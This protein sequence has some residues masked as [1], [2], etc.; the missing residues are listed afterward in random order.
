MWIA[1][2]LRL[3][4]N[5]DDARQF[6]STTEAD[7]SALWCS[8]TSILRVGGRA[9]LKPMKMNRKNKGKRNKAKTDNK[10]RS[11][12]KKIA[13]KKH[14]VKVT[15]ESEARIIIL[16]GTSMNAGEDS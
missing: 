4:A 14:S 6:P 9:G 11:N 15:K 3:K 13:K 2:S 16:R 10:M 8:Y 5:L 1:S 12:K 7:F